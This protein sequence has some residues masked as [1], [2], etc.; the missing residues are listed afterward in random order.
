[1]AASAE[2]RSA[3]SSTRPDGT[4]EADV[5][6]LDHL[7][8]LSSARLGGSAVRGRTRTRGRRRP[9]ILRHAPGP[10]RSAGARKSAHVTETAWRG[11]S[12]G[13]YSRRASRFRFRL[14]CEDIWLSGLRRARR[15]RR[16][17][18][19]R[20][21]SSTAWPTFNLFLRAAG[22]PCSPSCRADACAS[23]RS[24][25][26]SSPAPGVLP[27]PAPTTCYAIRSSWAASSWRSGRPW[28][29][30]ASA[31]SSPPGPWRSC[32]GRATRCW[33]KSR[34]CGDASAACTRTTGS[35]RGSWCP[36]RMLRP[37]G[38]FALTTDCAS[39]CRSAAPS[40]VPRSGPVFLVA[41]H[42]SYM[43]P[44][45]VM[46]GVPRKVRY[47]A[48]AVPLS[49]AHGRVVLPAHG[50][51]PAGAQPGR[52]APDDDGLQDPRRGR[53]GRDVPRRGPQLVRRDGLRALGVQG[54]RKAPGA[55]RHGGD[56]GSLRA[57][58]ALFAPP[59]PSPDPPA[60]SPAPA[61][62]HARALRG[63][64][65]GRAGAGRAAARALQAAAGAGRR[66]AAVRLPAVRGALPL[67]R[68]FRRP[69]WC[70]ACGS[71]FTLLEGKGLLGPAGVE[72]L[73]A[74]EARN[75][76]WS[77]VYDPGGLTIGGALVHRWTA[78]AG[79]R[80]AERPLA[81]QAGQGARCAPVRSASAMIGSP[82]SRTS[83]SATERSTR[84][85]S[86]ATGKWSSPTAG[87]GP[88]GAT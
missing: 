9:A 6:L 21:G 50:L 55:H 36:R 26:S 79:W 41:L 75:V 42:R 12:G 58:A 48:T 35:S 38:L 23:S 14:R 82:F 74:I 61:G 66:A 83:T 27:R 56:L 5:E 1:M 73:P 8:R 46:F 28:R 13:L 16:V 29:S 88:G 63:S 24:A 39:A 59:A 47:I 70:G 53:S 80:P 40:E 49:P 45:I 86:R 87:T 25:R 67:P 77:N 71:T 76:S 65:A 20:A 78:A 52:P 3:A 43:D 33:S 51:C 32:S 18:S 60:V 15:S 19:S 85:W 84:C 57:P 17:S 22:W 10:A 68:I 54:S 64:G 37:C 7:E 44:Y 69:H 4:V 30:P 72:S 62:A 11:R 31:P 34:R 81:A 2:A